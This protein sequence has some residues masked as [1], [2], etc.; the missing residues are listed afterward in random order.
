[1]PK[2]VLTHDLT[3]DIALGA[4]RG[5]VNWKN[6]ELLWSAFVNRVATTHR[7]A[8]KYT[9]YMAVAKSRQ[10]EIKDVGGYVGG[11]L[12]G[13][14][15]KNGR[16]LHRQLVTLDADFATPE[17][18]QNFL[19]LYGA[20]ACIYTTH[21]HSA[22][23]PRYRL[24]LPLDR[25]VTV[26]EY[27]PIA[28]RLADQ[29]GIDHFD[30][31]TFQ[32]TRLMY[33]PSTARD[34]AFEFHYQDRLPVS[35]DEVLAT[36][37]DY[38]DSSEWPMCVRETQL[39]NH[40]V[41]KQGDPLE[42]PGLIGAFCRTY[43]ITEAIDTFLSEDYE[44]C[45]V[46]DRYTYKQGSTAGGLV[47]YD[48]KYAFSHHGTDPVSGKL[49]N[50]FDLVR[51]HKFG[52]RDEDS[53]S[54]TP[55][56][57]LP[58]FTAMTEFC[59][60]DGRVRQQ[61]GSERTEQARAEFDVAYPVDEDSEP[62]NDLEPGP[63]VDTD[64]MA[65]LDVDRKGNTRSTIDNVII[66]FMNDPALKGRM[67]FNVFQM[68]EVAFKNLPWRKVA[69]H[70]R[71]LT[72]MD[73]KSIR[74]YLEKVYG[75]TAEKKITDGVSIA[76]WKNSFHPVKDFLESCRWDG[77]PRLNTLLVDYLG[78]EDCEYIYHV[79][80][81]T[82]VAAVARIYEPG[83][84]YDT[85]LTFIGPQG[86]LKSTML[87]KL[88][89][90]FFSDNFSTV[91]GSA[92]IE[93][94]QGVW[95]VEIA[96]LSGFRAYEVNAVKHYVARGTDRYRVAYGRR[97]ED[98]PRQCIFVGTVNERNFLKDPTG[99]RRFWPVMTNLTVPLFSVRDDL[100]DTEVRQIWAEAV[101]LYRAGELVY[102]SPEM[103]T[104][105]K[106]R[107][108]DHAERDD[109][110]G[111]VEA[112]LD[113]LLPA[114]WPD[115][116]IYARRGYLEGDELTEIGTVRRTKVCAAE[117]W[118]EVLKGDFKSMTTQNTKDLHNMMRKIPGWK[119]SGRTDFKI[120]GT[121]KYYQRLDADRSFTAVGRP[122][123]KDS[124]KL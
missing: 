2:I 41:K 25:P 63:P 71:N 35:A 95:I 72:D 112:Y 4:H 6:R 75:I 30:H 64:W 11:Y 99:D 43:G 74:H 59:T 85:V 13:G 65:A 39:V 46:E 91:Q 84:K 37:R 49:C 117:I 19:L 5:E 94:L 114:G 40:L 108:T 110:V 120:Y 87:S 31:T 28:R 1:M 60:R 12:A 8:E 54:D 98:F 32:A 82:F 50:A 20:A 111:L 69:P 89:R 33:W 26:E 17:L 80:R 86:N 61:L 36:Y 34:G 123:A 47:L 102:L 79:T 9:E 118:C 92:S 90:E 122:G 52:L 14:R 48:D 97:V 58:S 27:Q 66:I 116:S 76:L 57:K 106:R 101:H 22:N 56:N 119:E 3:F 103:E 83:C 23:A 67:G 51:L 115:L 53:R 18:W 7:T 29:L 100:T 55:S 45:D 24:I 70:S 93:Q 121:Q 10:D 78:A 124:S 15:R 62:T 38:V 21:K 42:K 44:P 68:R 105:A 88:G 77:Q 96:E 16:V 73:D 107:Q 113:T 104:E 109:R 81:K